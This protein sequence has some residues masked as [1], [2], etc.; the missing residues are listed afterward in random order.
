[1]HDV[2]ENA[3][4]AATAANGSGCE[5]RVADTTTLGAGVHCS[6]K[7]GW[8]AQSTL[9]RL[10]VALKDAM[11]RL[12]QG[13]SS[14]S[15]A[16]AATAHEQ[17]ASG[18]KRS[19][20]GATATSRPKIARSA[21]QG[22]D[23]SH[24]RAAPESPRVAAM[25]ETAAPSQPGDQVETRALLQSQIRGGAAVGSPAVGLE[26][27]AFGIFGDDGDEG[28]EEAGAGESAAEGEEPC[29]N[30]EADAGEEPEELVRSSGGEADE[31]DEEVPFGY[32]AMSDDDDGA[33]EEATEGLSFLA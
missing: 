27:E 16:V 9:D 20:H 25:A 23:H 15:A 31:E 26:L 19:A 10:R 17:P 21:G 29:D 28:E 32:A 33:R 3:P 12:A 2:D 5:E 14:A 18:G 7:S 13:E 11:R 6:V 8:Y 22:F 1:M 30:G 24:G 4:T